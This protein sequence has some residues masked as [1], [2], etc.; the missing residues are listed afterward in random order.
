MR[1]SNKWMVGHG[2]RA[3]VTATDKLTT[4]RQN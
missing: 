4:Q 1:N 3:A 2:G